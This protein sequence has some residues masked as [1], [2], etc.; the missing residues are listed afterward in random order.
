MRTKICTGACGERLPLNEIYFAYKNKKMR[1][2]RSNCKSC[3][4]SKKSSKYEKDSTIKAS[5]LARTN[6]IRKRNRKIVTEY[7]KQ[8]P[9]CD[10]GEADI[11]V[12]EFDHVLGDKHDNISAMVRHRSSVEVIMR[13]IHKCEV[14]CANCHRRRTAKRGSW[15][16]YLDC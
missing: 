1:I 15:Y 5:T 12:L 4:N 16:G 7:L 9:C 3:Y 6:L 13:E 2:F 14:V 8:H 11:F 10:C